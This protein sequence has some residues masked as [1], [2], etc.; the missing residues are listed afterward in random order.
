MI[1]SCH[2]LSGDAHFLFSSIYLKY[3]FLFGAL[4]EYGLIMF[5]KGEEHSFLHQCKTLDPE[6]HPMLLYVCL[7]NA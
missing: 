7:N 2:V 4:L 6:D 5:S 3:H 1:P